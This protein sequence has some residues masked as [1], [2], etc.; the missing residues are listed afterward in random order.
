MRFSVGMVRLSLSQ[1]ACGVVPGAADGA[2]QRG[3]EFVDGRAAQDRGTPLGGIE[4]RR[5]SVKGLGF[6]GMEGVHGQAPGVGE[7]TLGKRAGAGNSTPL[8][9]V[10]QPAQ[11][12]LPSPRLP[13]RP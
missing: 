7:A 6:V 5:V 1:R 11:H 8:K 3:P 9:G 13:F 4:P 10:L 12:R 2:E